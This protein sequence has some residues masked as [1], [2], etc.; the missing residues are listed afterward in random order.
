MFWCVMYFQPFYNL[1]ASVG[2][3]ILYKETGLRVETEKELLQKASNRDDCDSITE[4]I[5][6]HLNL[7]AKSE[8]VSVIRDDRLARITEL[9][10]FLKAHP[11][12]ITVFEGNLSSY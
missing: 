7:T 6:Q 3:N 5:F 10:N 12:K 8:T 9:C 11:S 1:S 2:A 4:E